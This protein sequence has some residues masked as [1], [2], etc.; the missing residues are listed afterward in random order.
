MDM[1]CMF[2]YEREGRC[3]A[4]A[5]WAIRM[6]PKPCG[7]PAANEGVRESRPASPQLYCEHHIATAARDRFKKSL[8][9]TVCGDT[10]DSEARMIG[11]E[12]I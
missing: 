7:C 4:E 8:E 5:A 6:G 12:R 1:T 11:I 9:C 2:R 3:M 10:F